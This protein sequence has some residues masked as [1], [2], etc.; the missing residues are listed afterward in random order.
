MKCICLQ[1]LPLLI[2]PLT[3]IDPPLNNHIR[4]YLIHAMIDYKNYN[5]TLNMQNYERKNN[6]TKTNG[7]TVFFLMGYSH[8][9]VKVT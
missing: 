8:T 7:K 9:D 2:N 6:N 5:I 1:K 4:Q 3:L